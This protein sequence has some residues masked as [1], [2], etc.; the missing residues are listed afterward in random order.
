MTV[1]TDS[2]MLD[3]VKTAIYQLTLGG[4]QSYTINGRT[5]TRM[6][7]T[8]LRTLR[9]D[10]ELRVAQAAGGHDTGVVQL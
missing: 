8:E 10:L 7:L 2:E 6:N 5:V 4:V 1:P 3:A 9:Q